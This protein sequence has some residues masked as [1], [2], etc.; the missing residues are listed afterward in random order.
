[1]S[2]EYT[3]MR[4]WE[5]LEGMDRDG[6]NLLPVKVDEEFRGMHSREDVVSYPRTMRC[7]GP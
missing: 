5:V 4:L 6:V 1:M 7:P 2:S 3:D